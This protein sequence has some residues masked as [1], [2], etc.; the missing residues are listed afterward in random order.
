MGL[1][2]SLIIKNKNSLN[3]SLVFQRS[4]RLGRENVGERRPLF[5]GL[6]LPLL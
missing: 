1:S 2:E 6:G 3:E 5:F 4:C